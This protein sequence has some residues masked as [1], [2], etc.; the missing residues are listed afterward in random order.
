MNTPR[1]LPR[2]I[3]VGVGPDGTPMVLLEYDDN[4]RRRRAW[5]ADDAPAEIRA[6]DR[7]RYGRVLRVE[8][9]IGAAPDVLNQNS[10]QPRP[11][12]RV[13]S[14]AARQ[15]RINAYR[16][17]RYARQREQ[18]LATNVPG[19]PTC[20]PN[21]ANAGLQPCA[22][23]KPAGDVANRIDT[24]VVIRATIGIVGH[25]RTLPHS[26]LRRPGWPH[27][28]APGGHTG[29]HSRTLRAEVD[30]RRSASAQVAAQDRAEQ[31]PVSARPLYSFK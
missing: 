12:R 2:R 22:P 24:P 17:E 26:K 9:S 6:A 25:S 23:M 10:S 13:L 27:S 14:P 11:R 15:A 29:R 18:I 28:L 30:P 7:A 19:G 8:G 1:T 4:G 3:A 20:H 21:S 5:I 16:R 31:K